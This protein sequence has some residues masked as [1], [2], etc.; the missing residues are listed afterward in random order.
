[1]GRMQHPAQP[2]EWCRAAMFFSKPFELSFLVPEALW[3]KP[4]ILPHSLPGKGRGK[5]GDGTKSRARHRKPRTESGRCRE[6][7]GDGHRFS[8]ALGPWPA[9]GVG[10]VMTLARCVQ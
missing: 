10:L 4:I 8:V 9:G 7:G 3:H 5:E 6:K 2:G 1:M